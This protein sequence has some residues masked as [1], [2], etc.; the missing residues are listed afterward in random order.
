M[1]QQSYFCVCIQKI[2]SQ[3]IK[4]MLAPVF[5]TALLAVTKEWKQP[6]CQLAE[7]WIKK[8]QTSIKK[9]EILSSATSLNLKDLY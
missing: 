3:D 8:R 2:W 9:K 6:K 7:E 1:I 5:S 4:K